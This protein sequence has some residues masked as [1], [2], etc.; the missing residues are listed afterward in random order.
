MVKFTE[1]GPENTKPINGVVSMLPVRELARCV[2]T[3]FRSLFLG[4]NV[5]SLRFWSKPRDAYQYWNACLFLSDSMAAG[6]LQ[7]KHVWEVFQDTPRETQ[8]HFPVLQKSWISYDP[9]YLADLVHLGFL[10]QAIQPRTIFEIGTSTGYSSLFLAANTCPDTQIWTLDLPDAKVGTHGS[11]TFYD[12]QIVEDCH[13]KEPCFVGHALGKKI[14]RVYGDSARFD[15]LPYQRSIDLFFVDGAHT[16]QYV[17]SDTI[18]A[19]R[20]CRP[21]SVI[22]W[23]DY[24]RSGLSRDVTKWLEELS[25]IVPVYAAHGSSLAFMSCDFDC[26][27]LARRLGGQEFG[28]DESR[29]GEEAVTKSGRTA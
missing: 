6:G 29:P 17:R 27:A 18:N 25:R 1:S 2:Q 28:S 12:R 13:K 9:S 14:Q 24:R 8:I 11:L 23:H 10:C 15:F 4:A 3:G 20:C 5:S 21:G 16:Y 19:L 26:G 22:A 7:K